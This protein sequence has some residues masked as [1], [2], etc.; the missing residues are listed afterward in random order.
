MT[1]HAFATE[2]SFIIKFCQENSPKLSFTQHIELL[3][4]L[5]SFFMYD[6]DIVRLIKYG[7]AGVPECSSCIIQIHVGLEK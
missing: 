2:S 6:K 7:F 4:P 1:A 5:H 3:I